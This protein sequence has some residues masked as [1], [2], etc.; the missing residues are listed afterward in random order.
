MFKEDAAKFAEDQRQFEQMA[1]AQALGMGSDKANVERLT[2]WECINTRGVA[3]RQ[4]FGDMEARV[5]DRLGPKYQD[6][7]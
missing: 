1:Q 7:I 3:Y 5:L 2:F 6:V 4:N